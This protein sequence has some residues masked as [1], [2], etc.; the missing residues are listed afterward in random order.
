M[1]KLSKINESIWSDI[2]KRSNGEKVRK[3]DDD[4]KTFK[5]YLETHYKITDE[6]KDR[7]YN[8]ISHNQ[9]YTNVSIIAFAY[10]DKD[11]PGWSLF[12]LSLKEKDNGENEI[13]LNKTAQKLH[14]FDRLR[15][16]FVL[17]DADTWD[18]IITPKSG[19]V[20]KQFFYKV[21]DFIIEN[22]EY[23]ELKIVERI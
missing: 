9:I 16:E 19:K 7:E 15:E 6:F 4:M 2:H 14:I 21:L 5:H 18:Y 23:P 17:T 12:H 13:Q 3:E 11:I 10:K 22:V 8:M 20:N 1:K